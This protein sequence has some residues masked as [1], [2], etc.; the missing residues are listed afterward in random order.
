MKVSLMKSCPTCKGKVNTRNTWC[1]YCNHKFTKKRKLEPTN[2]DVILE[3]N[4]KK[5][6]FIKNKP[7]IEFKWLKSNL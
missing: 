4:G 5:L 1:P 7:D 3:Y 6:K 2:L